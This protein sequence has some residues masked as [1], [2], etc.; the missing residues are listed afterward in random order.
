MCLKNNEVLN[1][2]AS[3][4]SNVEHSEELNKLEEELIDTLKSDECDI[5]FTVMCNRQEVKKEKLPLE[6][7]GTTK[8]LKDDISMKDS[9]GDSIEYDDQD[10]YDSDIDVDEH[11][12]TIAI[13]EDEETAEDKSREP[14]QT[15]AVGDRQLN[16]SFHDNQKLNI[17]PHI[18]QQNSKG[19]HEDEDD[20]CSDGKFKFLSSSLL[21]FASHI[22]SQLFCV[23]RATKLSILIL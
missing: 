23:T 16:N 19:S 21:L 5:D 6:E 12:L 14:S 3:K 22:C 11:K 4:L 15:N 17:Q 20:F 10:N 1:L 18:E 7:T 8:Y 2:Y 9:L 13:S